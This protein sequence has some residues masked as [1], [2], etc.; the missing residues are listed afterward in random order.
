M[1]N[2]NLNPK[3]NRARDRQQARSQR[4]KPTAMA[5]PRHGD[6][7]MPTQR[8]PPAVPSSIPAALSNVME[9]V[10]HLPNTLRRFDWARLGTVLGVW[11][12]DALWYVTHRPVFGQAA[13]AFGAV[14][15]LLF[16]AS[17]VLGGRIFPNVWAL[18]VSLG[19]LTVSEAQTALETAWTQDVRIQLYVQGIP[20]L[21][22]MP[23]TLGLGID[24]AAAAAA[25]KNVGMAGM[26]LGYSIAPTMTFDYA[27]AQRYLLELTPEINQL[28]FNAGYQMVDG[29]VVGVDGREGRELD[30]TATLEYLQTHLDDV[31]RTRRLDL[32]TLP[33]PPEVRDP[34]P[35]IADAQ[36]LVTQGFSLVGYDPFMDTQTAWSTTP[37][38]IVSWLEAGSG[39]LT[40]RRSA[41]KAFIATLNTQIAVEDSTRYIDAEEAADEMDKMLSAQSD[42]L[43]LRFKHRSEQYTV[44]SGDTG[45]R[46]SRKTGIPFF[47]ITEANSG[48]NWDEP[49]YVGDVI[50]LPSKD[51]TLPVAPIAT[52]RIV[53]DLN[54]QLLVAFENG[55]EKFRWLISSGME[56]AIT[57]PGIYQVLTHNDVAYGSSYTMCDASFQCDQWTMYY[58]MGIYEVQEGLMNGFHGAVE[59]PDGTYLGGG[60]V[61]EPYTFGCVMSENNNAALLYEWADL[62]TMVEIVSNE[63]EPRSDLAR[64]V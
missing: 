62:G 64:S 39:N 10:R 25:A 12:R 11:W 37:A 22:T 46:I 19:D 42:T 53:V 45:F 47:M 27:I 52:K 31:L 63:F 59:L 13:A 16:I 9:T 26:P 40:A 23:A 24:A 28:A 51:V 54:K 14:L 1:D 8:T 43:Y 32:L 15:L 33:L 2:A 18:G 38:E 21:D 56:D 55:E 44:Q 34:G 20:D 7:A 5:T 58:F 36:R 30:I 57:S 3:P 61:G 17:Y 48:R 4:R 49:L 41:F 35:Y 60:N 50:T 6:P 29:Q